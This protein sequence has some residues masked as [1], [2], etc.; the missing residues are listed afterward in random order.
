MQEIFN[1]KILRIHRD[2]VATKINDSD[3]LFRESLADI[4]ERANIYKQKYDTVLNVGSRVFDICSSSAGIEFSRLVNTDM[5]FNMLQKLKGIKVQSDEE[6]I[7]FL[8][9]S[10]DLAISNLNLHWVNDLPGALSQIKNT[11]KE[12]GL[13]VASFFGENSLR[14][15]K[16]V[17][18]RTESELNKNINFHVSPTISTEM[19]TSL[20][21]RAGFQDIVVDKNPVTVLYKDPYK[22][23]SDIRNMGESNCMNSGKVR[24]LRKDVLKQFSKNYFEMFSN[25]E[26]EI[27]CSYDILTCVG[28]K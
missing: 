10:F 16:E 23:L 27:A 8:D 12:G 13:F 22:V 11:L 19:L 20:M 3:F 4:I 9:D 14:E 25:R 28:Y 21:K 17:F 15:I 5:S 2:R 7:P 1:R 6:L 18:I 26:G 24:Y